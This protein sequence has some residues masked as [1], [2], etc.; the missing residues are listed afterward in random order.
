MLMQEERELVVE[1]GRKMSADRLSTGTSGNISVYNAEKGLMAISPSGM[2]Y[3]STTP[4]DVVITDLEANIVDG[5]RKP[6]SEWALHT[7]F[8]RHKPHARAVVHTHSMYCTTFAV[9]GQ[10]LRAVH[11]A[12]GDTGAATV[13]CAPYRLFGTAELAEAAIEACGGSD[14]VLLSNHGL[15]A[16]GRDLKGAYGLACNL[17]YVAELQY[18][19]MCIGTPNILTDEQMAEVMERFRSYGQPGSGKAGY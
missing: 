4:E 2:D 5:V 6:S 3:F 18:R 8:Y 16:C 19:T 9:L 1:Y 14:A 7:A 13:P 12:I 10:P 15:V 11:Y 17:E